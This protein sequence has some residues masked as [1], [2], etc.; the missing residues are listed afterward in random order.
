MVASFIKHSEQD[1]LYIIETNRFQNT[2]SVHEQ[3]AGH[4]A[5]VVQCGGT[6]RAT[7]IYNNYVLDRQCLGAPLSR[8]M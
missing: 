8:Y 7:S 5:A 6:R 1:D 3:N 4:V 2:V